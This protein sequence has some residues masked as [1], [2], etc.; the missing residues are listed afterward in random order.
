MHNGQ[1]G[2]QLL[3]TVK[4]A[5]NRGRNIIMISSTKNE[6]QDFVS[7]GNA[8]FIIKLGGWKANK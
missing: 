3:T 7:G 4:N 6:Q 2:H 1:R 5:A 8:K